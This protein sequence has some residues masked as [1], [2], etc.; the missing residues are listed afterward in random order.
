MPI[1]DSVEQLS[2]AGYRYYGFLCREMNARSACQLEYSN[3]EIA[4]RTRIKDPKTIKKARKELQTA[5]LI[6]CSQVPPGVYLHVM[7]DQFGD[8]I[9]PPEGRK[10]IRRYSSGSDSRRTTKTARESRGSHPE[11]PMPPCPGRSE[12]VAHVPPIPCYACHGTKFWTREGERVCSLCH[13]DPKSPESWN[14]PT[15]KEIGFE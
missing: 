2:P 7:L 12:E 9:P 15:A 14:P 10:G 1:A 3:A 6:E 8:P 11:S 4:D 13:P 5:R